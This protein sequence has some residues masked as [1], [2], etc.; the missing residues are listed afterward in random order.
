MQLERKI[1]GSASSTVQPVSD[2]K[3]QTLEFVESDCV[4]V[5]TVIMRV[6]DEVL[7]EALPP[8]E[9]LSFFSARFVPADNEVELL[10]GSALQGGGF[11]GLPFHQFAITRLLT[12][13][14]ILYS[15]VLLSQA[16]ATMIA[17]AQA[18]ATK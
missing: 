16:K 4:A 11:H 5:F 12:P 3:I 14:H 10:F 7:L 1:L 9:S 8:F 2:E 6:P 15:R 18:R 17:D 13:L